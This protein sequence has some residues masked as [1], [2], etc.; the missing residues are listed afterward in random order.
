[1]NRSAWILAS[2]LAAACAGPVQVAEKLAAPPEPRHRRDFTEDAHRVCESARLVLLGEGYV[3]ERQP[4]GG[5]V[6][7]REAPVKT[8]KE[9]AYA[10]FRVYA[11]C[12]PRDGGGSTLFV[13]ATEEQFGVKPI[14]ESTLL[15]LPLVSPISVGRRTEGDQQVKFRGRTIEEQD[16]YDGFYRSVRESLGRSP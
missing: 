2:V 7:A 11:S 1:M 9:D 13:T 3:V 8:E 12:V 6:G 5:Y 10:H 14:R 16:F 15:G 4:E